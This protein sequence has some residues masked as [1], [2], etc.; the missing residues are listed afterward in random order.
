ML[1]WLATVFL[2]PVLV[3][4]KS[5]VLVHCCL[6]ARPLH[7]DLDFI[8]I[9]SF[10]FSH[11]K[12]CIV[13]SLFLEF[14]N[15]TRQVPKY[16]WDLGVASKWLIHSVFSPLVYFLYYLFLFPPSRILITHDLPLQY[17]PF[18]SLSSFSSQFPLLC[19][20][21]RVFPTCFSKQVIEFLN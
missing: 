18:T 19:S 16:S 12:V 8:F 13:F 5:T 15:Y 20:C 14:R 10:H 6:A 21:P 2:V 4:P 11:H 7:K 3:S 17:P 9:I 1:P